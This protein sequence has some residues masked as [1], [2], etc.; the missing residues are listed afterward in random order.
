MIKIIAEGNK[1]I[2]QEVGYESFTFNGGE[3]HV[4][5]N[6][7]WRTEEVTII[8]KIRSSKEALQL[9]LIADALRNVGAKVLHLKMPY[10]PYGR[11]DRACEMGEAFSL[12]VF[13]DFLNSINFDSVSIVDPHSDVSPAL[14]RNCRVIKQLTVVDKFLAPTPQTPK[15]FLCP[16]ETFPVSP[17]AGANKKVFE[18]SQYCLK[19]MIR[20]DKLRD[21]S[22]GEIKETTVY[23]DVEGKNVTIYDDICDG[24]RTFIELAKVLKA[25]GANKIYLYVTHGIFANGIQCLLDA[26]I[27]HIFTTDSM[28]LPSH[29]HSLEN[30]TIINIEDI[31]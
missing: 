25:K 5:L 2:T 9:A 4:K 12:R 8:A 27:D 19:P 21:T 16:T 7:A 17:D 6:M 11:Q 10:V 1:M 26:G 29:Y 18:I 15:D 22:N 23:G 13:C 28:D 20:A 30:I 3:E 14:I 24:G 31:L